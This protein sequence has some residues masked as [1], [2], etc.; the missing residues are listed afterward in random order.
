MAAFLA[1]FPGVPAPTMQPA[2]VPRK[3]TAK[4]TFAV[5]R[6]NVHPRSCLVRSSCTF[7][8]FWRMRASK[9]ISVQ[10][11][12]SIQRQNRECGVRNLP[13]TFDAEVVCGIKLATSSSTVLPSPTTSTTITTGDSNTSTTSVLPSKTSP[14]GNQ[15]NSVNSTPTQTPNS[16]QA[17]GVVLGSTALFL[18]M[19]GILL[20]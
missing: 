15:T 10:F 1:V 20:G 3:L 2:C 6:R 8:Q 9:N 18:L 13:F 16:A 5:W 19:C 12:D 4:H 7:T 11:L 17:E 14:T